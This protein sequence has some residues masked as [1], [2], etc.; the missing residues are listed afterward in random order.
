[1]NP[2]QLLIV[3]DSKNDVELL[4]YTLKKARIDF[5]LRQVQTEEELVQ[6][7]NET[8]PDIVLSDNSLP[9]LDGERAYDI[10]H[11]FASEIPFVV[12]SGAVPE[13]FQAIKA[14]G[15]SHRVS[16]KD[17]DLMPDLI[18]RTIEE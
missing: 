11:A 1:M 10:V 3:E 8:R 16:K 9:R 14:L 12:F 18:L 4:S 2:I 5:I 15:V 17:L 6:A 7:L 13:K